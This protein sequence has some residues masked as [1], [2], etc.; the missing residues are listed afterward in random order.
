[1][2]SNLLIEQHFHGCYGIDFNKASVEE[3]L[4]L[5]KNILN[6]GIGFIFPTLV[7]DSIENLK[8]QIKIIKTAS[9]K[10]TDDMAQICGIHLE[11]NF[12][13]P[14]KKG[15]H[16]EKY[17]LEPNLEN[18]KQLEDDFIKI[19]TLAPELSS[20]ELLNY[21][22]NKG[23]KIQA[24]HCIGSDLTLC[25]GTTHTFNAMSP[26]SHK[27]QSTT[28][29]ALINENVYSEII[30]DGVHVCDDALKLFFKSKPTDKVILVS[31]CLPCTKSDLSEFIF[32]D[33][34]IYFN[35]VKATSKEGTLAG[36]TSLLPEIIK[37]LASKNLFNKEYITN[38]YKYHSISPKGEIEWDENYNIV[39]IKF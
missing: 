38:P 26:I 34:K 2:N 21:L 23:I 18:F 17:F 22:K 30:G 13:N 27:N 4:Y 35:G 3:V 28:L 33:E 14:I 20:T 29:S 19:V 12:L 5:A 24:G 25:D 32:A 39:K 8:R 1:M 15:I 6:E 31:D 16:N 36:S 10:Q 37:K 9:Q 11:G 7:T